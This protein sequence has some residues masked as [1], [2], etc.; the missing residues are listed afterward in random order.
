MK[1][2]SKV[3]QSATLART[4][5]D[6]FRSATGTLRLEILPSGENPM[7]QRYS[8]RIVPELVTSLRDEGLLTSLVTLD[9]PRF[10]NY[11]NRPANL[12]HDGWSYVDVEVEGSA[13]YRLGDPEGI[14]QELTICRQTRQATLTTYHPQVGKMQR[15]VYSLSGKD[16][17]EN[18]LEHELGN[19]KALHAFFF[20]NRREGHLRRL[21]TET[22]AA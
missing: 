3:Y 7:N 20:L 12:L 5:Q 4:D 11:L 17:L 2:T 1:F 9:T 10:A 14:R 6:F 18:S 19:Y 21:A 8:A 22:K 16:I 13:L 15:L